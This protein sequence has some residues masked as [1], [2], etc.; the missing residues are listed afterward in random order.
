MLVS[1]WYDV[2]TPDPSDKDVSQPHGL[3]GIILALQL[4]EE[5]GDGS[6]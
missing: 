5:A 6:T 3:S 4:E 2:R 1:A